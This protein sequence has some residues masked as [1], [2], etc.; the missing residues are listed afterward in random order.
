MAQTYRLCV[1]TPSVKPYKEATFPFSS[2][3][4][5]SHSL[6][7]LSIFTKEPFLHDHIGVQPEISSSLEQ[8]VLS[9]V[10]VEVFVVA[11]A[12][13]FCMSAENFEA[14]EDKT[15]V[16]RTGGLAYI[17]RVGFHVLRAVLF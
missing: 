14:K 5:T 13:F 8:S 11:V 15:K 3:V 12:L 1:C 2:S 7:A 16:F 9:P 17:G 10:C 6:P 4:I